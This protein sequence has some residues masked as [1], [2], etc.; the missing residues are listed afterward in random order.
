M[1]KKPSK[2][3]PFLY[4]DWKNHDIFEEKCKQELMICPV[5]KHFGHKTS[6]LNQ[7][8]TRVE[9]NIPQTEVIVYASHSHFTDTDVGRHIRCIIKRVWIDDNHLYVTKRLRKRDL[10]DWL[11][12]DLFT[13]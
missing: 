8:N 5:C 3:D 4:K 13:N 10:P 7:A 2:Y 12:D 11:K 6:N 9:N 1:S